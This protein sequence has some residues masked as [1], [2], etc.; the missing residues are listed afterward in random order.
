MSLINP[1]SICNLYLC[2][3]TRGH[4][5]FTIKIRIENKKFIFKNKI[6]EFAKQKTPQNKGP[7][8]KKKKG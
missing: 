5:R 3:M 8:E 4:R 6:S 7:K 2:R 1:Y